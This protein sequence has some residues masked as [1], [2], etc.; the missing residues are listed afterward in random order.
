MK[1]EHSKRVELDGRVFY[2]RYAH[3]KPLRIDERRVYKGPYNIEGVY[4]QTRWHASSH[5][6]PKRPSAIAYRVLEAAGARQ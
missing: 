4:N 2:V 3:G 1:T 5:P 6:F